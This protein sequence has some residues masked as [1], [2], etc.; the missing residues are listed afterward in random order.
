VFFGDA[1]FNFVQILQLLPKFRSI[2][3][4]SNRY[5]STKSFLGDVTP[6]RHW[7]K[8]FKSIKF[9]KCAFLLMKML[10]KLQLPG[11]R[12]GPRWGRFQCSSSSW[13]DWVQFV[14]GTVFL[15]T[16]WICS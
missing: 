14:R 3:P 7:L 16:L 1:K 8:Q 6:A 13:C 4:K 11:L 2:L 12:P 15:I 10:L 9:I 5:Y